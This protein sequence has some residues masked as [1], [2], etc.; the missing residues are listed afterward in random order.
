MHFPSDA[1]PKNTNINL[2]LKY[3]EG[4]FEYQVIIFNKIMG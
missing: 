4:I 1:T 2:L 3:V